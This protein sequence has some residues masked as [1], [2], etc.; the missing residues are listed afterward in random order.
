M[1]RIVLLLCIGSSLA[2]VR[3]AWVWLAR[4]DAH[5]R[6]ERAALARRGDAG[7]PPEDDS[8]AVRITQFYARSIE[9]TDGDPNLVCYGVRNAASVRIEPP[10]ETL[11][12]AMNQCFFVEPHQ[13]TTYKLVADG[14]DGSQA[15]ESFQV[16]VKPSPPQILMLAT[17]ERKVP[18]GEAVTLCYG[19][20]HALNVRLEPNGWELPPVS[21]NCTR[22]YPKASATYS[23]VAKGE[24][25]TLRK[26]FSV[27]VQ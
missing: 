2:A 20:G 6:V 23:L 27:T 3:L 22:F 18:R 11:F 7:R 10:V 1:K 12:P 8:G 16:R 14:T 21:K 9:M 17:S 26:E 4:Q 13:D 19:V 25:G 5:T 24:G 15:S